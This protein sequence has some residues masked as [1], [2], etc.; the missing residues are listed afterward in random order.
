MT[1]LYKLFVM[2]QFYKHFVITQL[3]K[4]FAT[5]LHYTFSPWLHRC[6]VLTQLCKYFAMS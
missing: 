2:S 3:Y 4:I 6:V 1:P 5:T